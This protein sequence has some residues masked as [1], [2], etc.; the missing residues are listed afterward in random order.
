ML[1]EGTRRGQIVARAFVTCY[2]VCVGE[3]LASKNTEVGVLRLRAK[4]KEVWC[5]SVMNCTRPMVEQV[6]GSVERVGPERE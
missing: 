6:G 5:G 1:S 2:R 3:A 4:E